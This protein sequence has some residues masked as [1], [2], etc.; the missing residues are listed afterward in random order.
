VPKRSEGLA[1][2]V[3]ERSDQAQTVT[4]AMAS[5]CGCYLVYI[6]YYKEPIVKVIDFSQS[7]DL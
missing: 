4:T 7:A 1:W 2:F 5:Q 6:Y 3:Q